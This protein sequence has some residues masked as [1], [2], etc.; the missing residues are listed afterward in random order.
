VALILIASGQL[1]AQENE[2]QLTRGEPLANV[3]SG[4]DAGQQYALYMP[5]DYDRTTSLPVLILMDPRGR[6]MIPLSLFQRGAEEFGYLILSSYGTLSDDPTAFDQ[7]ERA[8]NAMLVD[9]QARFLADPSRIYLVGFSGT[10]HYAWNVAPQLDGSLAG[11]VGVGGGLPAYTKPIQMGMAMDHPFAFFGVAGIG[12]F[13]YDGV[14]WLDEALD[15]TRV[16]HRFV[17]HDGRHQWPA[18]E[19]AYEAVEWFEIQAMKD[20]IVD[21][22]MN[23]VRRQFEAAMKET[24]QLERDDDHASAYRRYREIV[25][26]FETLTDTDE[27]E[28][29]LRRMTNDSDVVEE[30]RRRDE[31]SRT[32]LL[33]KLEAQRFRAEYQKTSPVIEHDVAMRRLK[34]SD[35]IKQAKDRDYQE[36]GAARRMLAS[37]FANAG[38]YEPRAY[39]RARDFERAAGVL[40]IAQAIFPDQPRTCYQ[41]AQATAQ[42][43]RTHEAIDALRCAVEADWV[44]PESIE[45]DELLDPIRETSG[46]HELLTTN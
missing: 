14:R 13:N 25:A 44:T 8:L 11:V 31:L 22:D 19:I 26:D 21:E 20:G 18:E 23:F 5:S 24:R 38:F 42:L 33:Y 7:N 27:A 41:L 28:K 6:A 9:A 17:T 15:T 35:L 40:Y 2:L 34:I 46:Y 30:Q 1:S 45:T 3:V 29:R 43:G 37:A 10:A 16:Q 12:D 4:S 39:L 32:V 36:S